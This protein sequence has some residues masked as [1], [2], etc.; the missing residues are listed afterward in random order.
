[1]LTKC[2]VSVKRQEGHFASEKQSNSAEKKQMVGA[3]IPLLFRALKIFGLVRDS[4]PHP[5]LLRPQKFRVNLEAKWQL[6]VT[7]IQL[8]SC[9]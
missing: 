2:F 4:N 5:L 7:E 3:F 9:V 8:R 1:M 6:D